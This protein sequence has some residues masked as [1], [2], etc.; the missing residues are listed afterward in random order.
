MNL[1]PDFG[2]WNLTFLPKINIVAG[3]EKG[4]SLAA[5][6]RVHF[7]VTSSW[8]LHALEGSLINMILLAV[9]FL[10]FISSYSASVKGK[11]V[12]PSAKL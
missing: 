1:G 8:E 11:F 6:E 12:L 4:H 2:V 9:L 7:S 3:S 5:A 10:C